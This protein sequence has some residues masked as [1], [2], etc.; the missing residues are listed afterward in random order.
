[1][2]YYP[3]MV[4][5]GDSETGRIVNSEIEEIEAS[6]GG[7]ESHWLTEI[8]EAQKG[9]ESEILRGEPEVT[10]IKKQNKKGK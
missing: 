5:K 4:Y 1:M 9:T 7:Y 3:R 8:I 6:K 2:K 10:E